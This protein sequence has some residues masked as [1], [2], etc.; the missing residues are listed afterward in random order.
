MTISKTQPAIPDWLPDWTKQDQYPDPK[1]TSLRQWTWEFLRRN[2]VYQRLWTELIAPFY[3]EKKGYQSLAA[4]KAAE[5]RA[6]T[7]PIIQRMR[8]EKKPYSITPPH[9]VFEE[10]FGIQFY[11]PPPSQE[12]THPGRKPTFINERLKFAAK[13]PRRRMPEDEP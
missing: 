3:D 5:Q 7:D 13:L 9:V 1:K 6:E 12:F 4:W 10:R 8:A 2:P 11:P